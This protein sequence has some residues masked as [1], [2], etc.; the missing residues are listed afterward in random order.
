MPENKIK[1]S[2][3]NLK[4]IAA[5]KLTKIET[6]GDLIE[7]YKIKWCLKYNKPFKDP[8]LKTY[9]VYELFLEMMIIEFVDDPDSLKKFIALDNGEIEA[10]Q[11]DDEIW[12]KQT[13]GEGY[14]E[15]DYQSDNYKKTVT[16]ARKNLADDVPE[17]EHNF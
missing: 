2:L 7:L 12:F 10:I 4:R 6:V 8:L 17:G 15:E 1:F 9:N 13:M 3:D 16:T 5:S 14:T 11:A